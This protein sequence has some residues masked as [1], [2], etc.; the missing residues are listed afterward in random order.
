[1][2]R[3]AGRARRRDDVMLALHARRSAAVDS[4]PGPQAH[5]GR[6]L[7][8]VLTGTDLYRRHR[9]RRRRRSTRC[10]SRSGWWCCRTAAPRRCPRE[11][12]PKARVIFQSTPRSR[13]AAQ[14]AAPPAR[15]DGRPPAR[16]EE[17]RR[18]C[19]RPRA[20]WRQRPTSAS[21]TSATAGEPAWAE[22]ARATAAQLPRLPLAGRRC[23]TTTRRQAIQR[24]HVLVHTSAMEGGAHVI[25]EAVRSGTPVLASRVAGNVGMLG[26]DYEGYF[27]H[28]RCAPR[29]PP[30]CCA[31]A[32][33]RPI[34]E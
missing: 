1:M 10:S 15:G 5:P 28:G 25:M 12:R 7:A 8:V 3:L 11:L 2:Q 24:A 33:A 9:Q 30:C 27:E 18:R 16:G 34:R 29:W 6:G 4:R 14:D 22:Q 26:A 32:R 19:S 13:A 23:R 21:T 17:P 31:A 20:C